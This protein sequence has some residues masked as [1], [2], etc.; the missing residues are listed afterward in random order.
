MFSQDKT[1]QSFTASLR[2]P[3][4]SDQVRRNSL[5]SSGSIFEAEKK[6]QGM[7]GHAYLIYPIP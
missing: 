1:D 2:R 5:E 7:V 4:S 6:M 3:I